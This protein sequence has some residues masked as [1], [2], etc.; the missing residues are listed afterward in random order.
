M[1]HVSVGTFVIIWFGL[2]LRVVPTDGRRYSVM[3]TTA[4]GDSCES[5]DTFNTY[6]ISGDLET[7][8]TQFIP[9]SVGLTKTVLF[10]QD[11]IGQLNKLYV[12]GSN[13]N[14]RWCFD[15]FRILVN[16]TTNE[17]RNCSFK[18]MNYLALDSNCEVAFNG[19]YKHIYVN[20]SDSSKFCGSSITNI[21]SSGPQSMICFFLV[22]QCVIFVCCAR[23]TDVF[24]CIIFLILSQK[25]HI[26]CMLQISQH[27]IVPFVRPPRVFH[28][29]FFQIVHILIHH[30]Q[31]N[32]IVILTIVYQQMSNHLCQTF[33]I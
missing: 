22:L 8:P 5:N 1:M 33:L 29:I 3:F 9:A 10:E 12:G 25:P 26:D 32:S 15:D 30:Q 24:C 18:F 2:N 19:G 7:T 13:G 16:D 14:Y 20:I 27:L 17:W 21:S 28:G 4:D 31:H 6:F 11:D 23:I